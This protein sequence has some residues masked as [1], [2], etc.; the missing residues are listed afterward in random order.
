VLDYMI[1]EAIVLRAGEEDAEREKDRERAA[2]R[3][4][5]RSMGRKGP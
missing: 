5:H 3:K 1:P 2:W 4:Q